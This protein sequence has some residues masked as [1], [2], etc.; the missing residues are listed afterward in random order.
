MTGLAS[1]CAKSDRPPSAVLSDEE[2]IGTSTIDIDGERCDVD[3]W[4]NTIE[5]DEGIPIF[6][7]VALATTG[8]R[9]RIAGEQH[10]QLLRDK[11]VLLRELQH[12]VK[13]NLQML[14]ALI[15]MEARNV[16]DEETG[17]R[18]DRLAGRITCLSSTTILPSCGKRSLSSARAAMKQATASSASGAIQWCP[19]QLSATRSAETLINSGFLAPSAKVSSTIEIQRRAVQQGDGGVGKLILGPGWESRASANALL[20]TNPERLGHGC[21]RM[22]EIIAVDMGGTHARFARCEVGARRV[23][24]L[25]EPATFRTAEHASFQTAWEAFARQQDRPLPRDAAIAFAGPV[26][27]GLLKLTNNSWVIRP[28]SLPASVGLDRCRII[29]DFGA[30]AHAVAQLSGS[31]FRHLC[32]QETELPEQGVISVVGPGTGLGVALLL[33]E[34]ADYRVIETEGGHID[35]APHDGLE[36][37]ILYHL[38]SRYRR[39]SSN[40]WLRGWVSPT[41]TRRFPQSRGDR[42]KLVTRRSC[43]QRP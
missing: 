4:S 25:G 18:F 33:R 21:N 6:R 37:M 9:I 17:E 31:H 23:I 8:Q 22:T 34:R 42:F 38:R 24:S 40:G 7:L 41:S 35:F 27:G 3:A 2:H 32:G 16:A 39:V 29:N 20:Q 5:S 13:N 30:V 14:T 19:A 10:Y 43:G 28:A 36:D 26:E 1:L 11:D 12:R 15:R